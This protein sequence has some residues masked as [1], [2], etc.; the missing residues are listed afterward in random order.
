ML[1][2]LV[3]EFLDAVGA[4]TVK[5][6]SP[7]VNMFEIEKLWKISDLTVRYSK[8]RFM[9]SESMPP[10][11]ERC[12]TCLRVITLYAFFTRMVSL[13]CKGN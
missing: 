5:T 10:I 7:S 6:K 3:R 8:L 1:M 11:Y 2:K 13:R 4:A 9:L 12:L